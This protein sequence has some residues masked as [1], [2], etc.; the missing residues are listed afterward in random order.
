MEWRLLGTAALTLPES[1]INLTVFKGT[2]VISVL[3]PFVASWLPV[4][5]ANL[6]GSRVVTLVLLLSKPVV[7]PRAEFFH[8]LHKCGHGLWFVMAKV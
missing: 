4:P 7:L 6:G 2:A 3:V 8:H 1:G 5:V